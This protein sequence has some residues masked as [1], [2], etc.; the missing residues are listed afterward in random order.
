MHTDQ[1]LTFSL[2]PSVDSR[3]SLKVKK[4]VQSVCIA[5]QAEFRAPDKG[6]M[7]I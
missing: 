2:G 6:V 4:L 5:A 7:I 3:K 1:G